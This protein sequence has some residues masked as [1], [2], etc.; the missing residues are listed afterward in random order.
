MADSKLGYSDIG[1]IFISRGLKSSPHANHTITMILSFGEPVRIALRG[2]PE[3]PY[4]AVIIK[5]DI[6]YSLERSGIDNTIIRSP[7]PILAGRTKLYW[8]GQISLRTP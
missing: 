8:A 1:G 3:Q 4:K 5:K 6:H 7:R 2:E